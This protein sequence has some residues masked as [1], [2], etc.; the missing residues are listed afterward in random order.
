M[1]RSFAF[2]IRGQP[3]HLGF[4]S[5]SLLICATQT[6]SGEARLPTAAIV[7][8]DRAQRRF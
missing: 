7:Q 2:K 5:L 6:R 8:Q 1:Q 4:F 3:R